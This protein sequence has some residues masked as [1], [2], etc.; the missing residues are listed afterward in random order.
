MSGDTAHTHTHEWFAIHAPAVNKATRIVPHPTLQQQYPLERPPPSYHTSKDMRYTKFAPDL[1]PISETSIISSM[2]E[3]NGIKQLE[4]LRTRS[5]RSQSTPGSSSRRADPLALRRVRQ[6]SG[7]AI[8]ANGTPVVDEKYG[9][10]IL[11]NAVRKGDLD[12]MRS[13]IAQHPELL[14]TPDNR[15]NQ[16]LHYA[17]NATNPEGAQAVYL[18]LKAGAYVNAANDRNQ[19][20]LLVYAISTDDDS[21]L[22]PRILLHHN[23]KPM[24]K[25]NDEY[26]LP[27]YTASRG[28]HKIAAALREYM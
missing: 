1:T 13:L 11:H 4:G 15:G 19:T 8:L 14:R 7:S 17:A 16:P 3:K 23:A 10:T 12:A 22:I 27:Q 26:L 6:R 5:A 20:P 9:R 24:V 2:H 28:H 21:D 25:V 18:L